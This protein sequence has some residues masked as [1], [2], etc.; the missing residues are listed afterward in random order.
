MKSEVEKWLE[1]RG[2]GIKEEWTDN[3]EDMISLCESPL[4]KLFLIE[5]YYQ[6][7]N[8][9]SDGDLKDYLIVPQYKINNYRIDFFICLDNGV[10]DPYRY[11]ENCLI[12][13]IDS[14]LW[15]G[16][17]PEQFAKEKERER[18]LQKEGYKLMR[19]SGREIY[20]DVEKC[21]NEVANYFIEKKRNKIN[22]N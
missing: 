22:K 6:N 16:E 21:V 14:Y 1:K 19:F 15:H 17:E 20:R 10:I 5:W 18:E 11:K 9:Y 8:F 4:E 3:S 12:I 13:E 2:Q 7:Y